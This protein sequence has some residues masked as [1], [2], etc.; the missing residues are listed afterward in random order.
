MLLTSTGGFLLLLD[1][2]A[3]FKCFL[4]VLYGLWR[5]CIVADGSGSF[6]FDQCIVFFNMAWYR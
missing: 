4:I 2:E 3:R 5:L 6:C 1:V